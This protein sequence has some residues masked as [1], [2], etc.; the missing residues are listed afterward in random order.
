MKLS[1]ILF[2]VNIDFKVTNFL[3]KISYSLYIT[4]WPLGIVAEFIMKKIIPIHNNEVGKMILL[5]IYTI[6]SI[7]FAH[8]FYKFIELKSLKFSKKLK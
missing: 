2:E 1:N 5:I 8:F 4:H 6:T 7:L 3:G